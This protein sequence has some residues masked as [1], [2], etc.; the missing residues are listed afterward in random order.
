MYATFLTVHSLLRWVV[1]A[2]LFYAFFTAGWGWLARRPYTQANALAQQVV[3]G[4]THFQLLVGFTLYFVLSP[5]SSRFLRHGANGGDQ[6]WFFGLYHIGLMFASAVVLSVGS[7]LAKRATGD[8]A[9][10]KI[11]ALYIGLS[12]VLILLAI[13]WFRPWWRGF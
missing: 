13:P 11:I 9:K 10:F 12:L 1:L 5:V 3:T 6:L 8:Q 4:L 7:S 2:G